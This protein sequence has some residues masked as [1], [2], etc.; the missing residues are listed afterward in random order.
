MCDVGIEDSSFTGGDEE[1]GFAEFLRRL[2][3]GDEQAARELVRRY[4]PTI[5][6]AVRVRLRDPR[7]RRV[8]ESGD[9]CQAVFASFLVRTARGEYDLESPD[10]LLRLLATMARNK[11]ARHASRERAGRRDQRR[12]DPAVV[13]EEC[14]AAGDSPSGQTTAH[15]LVQ[16]AQS[17]LT[18]HERA[19]LE[20]RTQGRAWADIAAELG[21]SP[22]GLRVRLARA[23]ARLRRQLGLE[24]TADV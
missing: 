18:P 1:P 13:L 24:G 3:D 8:I 7:L 11:L 5:R 16:E 14:P 4:E 23:I 15:D 19:L 12:I 2:R 21:G 20:Q 6:R 22:D 9:I 17:R 10:Q